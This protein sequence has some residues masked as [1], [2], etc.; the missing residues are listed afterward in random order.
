MFM[1]KGFILTALLIG[2][3]ALCTQAQHL[4]PKRTSA[5]KA[6]FVVASDRFVRTDQPAKATGKTIRHAAATTVTPDWVCNFD[7]ES[8]FSQFTVIDANNDRESSA[9]LDWAVWNYLFKSGASPYGDDYPDHCAGYGCSEDNDAD[10]WLITPEFSLQAGATYVLRFKVR[11]H[12][13]SM[14]ERLEVKY[15]SAPTADAMT[16]TLMAATELANTEYMEYTQTITAHTDQVVYIGFHAVSEADNMILYLDDISVK[17]SA[18]AFKGWEC[19]FDKESDFS[20]FTV[21]DANN[22][23]ESS[24]YL[25]WAVWN[26]LF[27]SGASPYGD[28]YPDHCAGY[29]C[30]EDNDADDWL[31]T[32]EFSLQAGATYVLR[33]KVRVHRSSMPERLEVKYG[34][35]PTADAMTNTLMAA[36]E[37]NNTDFKEITQTICPTADGNYFVGFHAVSE[38]DN[39]I[40]YLDDISLKALGA[41]PPDTVTD[42]RL[43]PDPTG[44][45]TA[46]L[47]FKAPATASDGSALQELA[48]IKVLDGDREIAD[49]TNVEIG[50]A[51]QYTVVQT[52]D[53][54]ALCTYSVMAYNADGN[55]AKASVSGWV[56]L[57]APTAPAYATATAVDDKVNVEWEAAKAEHS[58]VFF[59]DK[60]TYDVCDM[61]DATTVSSKLAR[62]QGSTAAVLNINANSGNQRL[63]KIGVSASNTTGSSS[64]TLAAP[65]VVGTPYAL[66]FKETFAKD[67]N[68]YGFWESQGNGFGYQMGYAG[69]EAS[70][71]EDANGDGGSAKIS[72]YYEDCVSLVS[73]K[74]ALGQANKP[75]FRYSQKTASV[76]GTIRPFVIKS[77]G[78]LEY[79]AAESLDGYADSG[80]WVARSY[81]MSAYKGQPWIRLGIAFDQSTAKYKSNSLYIDNFIVIDETH[82]TLS[83][84]LSAPARMRKGHAGNVRVTVTNYG[85]AASGYTMTLTE[86]KTAIKHIAV[87]EPLAQMQTRIF[88][89]VYK[90]SALIEGQKVV[91][92][93]T[94]EAGEGSTA[95]AANAS[96]EVHVSDAQQPSATGLTAQVDQGR[97]R[98]AWTAAAEISQLTDDFEDYSEWSTDQAG[99][100]SFIDGDKGVTYGYFDIH[101]LYYNNEKTPFAYIVWTPTNYGGED[102]TVANPSAK[103]ASGLN[104]MASVYSYHRS[105]SGQ[106]TPLN[107]DNW[108]ISPE[109]TGEAQT[110]RFKVNNINASHPENYQVL[111][112]TTGKEVSD[113]Q[114]ISE[115]TVS[116]GLW[117]EVSTELPLGARY[118]A[119]RHCTKVV[120]N[121]SGVGYSSAPYLF[122]VDDV[123]MASMGCKF[124]GYNI[125]RDGQLLGSTTENRYIDLAVLGDSQNHTYQVTALYADGTESVPVT[126]TVNVPTGIDG[127]ETGAIAPATDTVFTLDGR[128]LNLKAPLHRGI[129]IK[130]GRK[131]VVK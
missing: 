78:T 37:F 52:A 44:A 82:E 21:I 97:V 93:A 98:L 7:K 127:I 2:L 65:M 23:R 53:R 55:G 85:N 46:T 118:L 9:Y 89:I 80:Q 112:S 72:T 75:V 104:A 100:W 51:V 50:K 121:P 17:K 90:P 128:K 43:T 15:G 126:A 47:D 25:D 115:K 57:D 22:D 103:P 106:L 109:L 116:S 35:A 88:D 99:D 3:V 8:D 92:T 60:V 40:L 12:R 114:L 73:G 68:A 119:I 63:L 32:P 70:A 39:M 11:V 74:I 122:L 123:T 105:E 45:L 96:F 102:I 33:F 86:G 66:P 64:Y 95:H 6:A 67:G 16:N 36:T 101:G 10:D 130:N 120:E 124:T 30:S 29:G 107:A 61:R 48:G 14:P 71:T 129:Y 49:I 18:T 42:L 79:L 24:A 4:V 34:S 1:K 26:Y 27:K 83:V 56:G 113:F 5:Q 84:G 111:Y 110:V 13:S 28:D 58:G 94:A 108:M 62:S 91:L 38:A 117:D 69:V 77:D 20:Q 54:P 59:A 81:D 125:Y 19:N 31:I 76:E 131:V 87:S 41:L